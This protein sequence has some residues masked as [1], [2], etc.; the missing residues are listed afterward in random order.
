MK[1]RFTYTLLEFFLLIGLISAVLYSD[2]SAQNLYW[3]K[4]NSALIR[5]NVADQNKIPLILIH[6]INGTKNCSAKENLNTY[7]NDFRLAFGRDQAVK[8]KFSIYVFQYCSN[9]VEVSDIALELRDLIDENLTDKN[10]LILAHS[11]GG[12]VAKSYMAETVHQKGIWKN[13]TGGDTT[14][15]I[16]TLGT[17]HHGTPGANSPETLDKLFRFGWKNAYKAANKIYW[18]E[19]LGEN[20]PAVENSGLPNRSDLRW[21]NYDFKLD[22]FSLDLNKNLFNRNILFKKYA[23]KL[24]AYSGYLN[25]SRLNTANKLLEEIGKWTITIETSDDARDHRRLE[26]ANS[27]LFYGL[28]ENFGETDGLVPVKSALVC[29]SDLTIS[30]PNQTPPPKPKN[31]VCKNPS[32]VRRFE[33]GQGGELPESEYP[34]WNTLSIYRSPRGFDHLDMLENPIV[35]DYVIKDLKNIGGVINNSPKPDKKFFIPELPTLFLLDISDSMNEKD[36]I[37]QAKNAG[38]EAVG[39]MQKNRKRGQDNSSVAVWTFGGECSPNNIKKLLPFSDNL[40]QAENTFRRGIPRPSG[41]TP[42]YT[43]INLSIDQMT[44]YLASRPQLHDARIVVMTDGLNTC[45]EQIRPQGVYSQSRNIIY[46]KVKFYCIGFDIAPGSKEERDLQY[47]ASASG[48]KYFPARNAAQLNRVFQKV[49]RVYAPKISGESETENGIRAI[50]EQNFDNALKIWTIHIKNNPTDADGFYNLALV[51][52]ATERYKCAV[53]NYKKYLQ[54]VSNAPD[55]NE[56]GQRIEKLLEDEQTEFEYYTDVLRSDLKYLKAYYK[57]LFGLKNDELAQEFAGFVA[58]KG[59]F[60]RNLPEILEIPS[61]RIG[62]NSTELAD[63]LDYLNRRVG[64]PSFDRDA[65]SLLTVPIS[66][67]EELIERIENYKS[68][69]MK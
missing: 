4:N 42:L 54:L 32:R 28:N 31:Y 12:L 44:S 1:G 7:W 69:N 61:S 27:A 6:G 23:S 66:H 49:I 17:P 37:G 63:S 53:E 14:I 46:Q 26:L 45:S 3:K 33:A 55:A 60:Y 39:E 67:L 64:S 35:L 24:I 36:K 38:L 22:S 11:M 18:S 57:R 25:S 48:G 58:E 41:L 68:E 34:N 29:D 65:V 19:S 10:H 2:A 40:T 5:L 15:G 30:A 9:L 21:D 43:A 50:L 13:K 20:H 62:R 16:I 51:C 59:A 52:E 56:I 47:L 8:N